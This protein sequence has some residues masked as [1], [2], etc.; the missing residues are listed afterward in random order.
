M[1]QK[2]TDTM[3]KINN[4]YIERAKAVSENRHQLIAQAEAEHQIQKAPSG[5]VKFLSQ[6]DRIKCVHKFFVTGSI[7]DVA[8]IFR[9]SH[10]DIMD[11]ARTSWWQ[12]ELAN[13]EREASCMLKVRLTTLMDK[14]F[15]QL[16]DRLDNGDT[17]FDSNG[18]ERKIPIPARDLAT[19]SNSIFDKKRALDETGSGFGSSE[20][21]RLMDLAAA[22]TAREVQ[23]GEI[24]DA[25]VIDVV[26]NE[27]KE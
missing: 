19:I 10:Q 16:E 1:G 17:K 20:T 12:T 13:L 24:L 25:D 22:L 23:P 18:E 11:M 2:A 3:M 26:T 27:I 4:E 8:K 6:E 5:N 21:K 15:D 7:S 9:L 14:T